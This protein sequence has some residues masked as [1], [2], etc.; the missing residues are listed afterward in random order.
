MS[1]SNTDHSQPLLPAIRRARLERM[2]IFEV[3]ESELE[4]L[5]RGSPNSLFLNLAI[6][7]L[8]TAI[9]FSVSLSTTTVASERTFNVFVI[10]MV[11]GYIAGVTFAL[12]WY[13]SHKSL[14]SVIAEIRS[15]LPPEGVQAQTDGEMEI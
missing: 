4:T 12:L 9:S 3:S 6:F 2:S 5:E 14:K 10:I 15:R 8:S 7:V 1:D 13:R 11:A